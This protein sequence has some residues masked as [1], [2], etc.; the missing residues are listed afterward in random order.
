MSLDDPAVQDRGEFSPITR[1]KKRKQKGLN[2]KM[3]PQSKVNNWGKTNHYYFSY[4]AFIWNWI[5][6]KSAIKPT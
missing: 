4:N 3:F 6:L 1:W 2:I 5:D